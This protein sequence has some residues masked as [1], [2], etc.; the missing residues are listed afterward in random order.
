M[1]KHVFPLRGSMVIYGQPTQDVDH[2]VCRIGANPNIAIDD[3]H[4]IAFGFAVRTA[5]VPDFGIGAQVVHVAT[6]AGEVRVLLFDI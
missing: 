1:H 4:N 5:H 6:G 2:A 3:P